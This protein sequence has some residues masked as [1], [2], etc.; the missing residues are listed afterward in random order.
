MHDDGSP[1]SISAYDDQAMP[2]QGVR[3]VVSFLLFLHFFAL[4]VGIAS[5]WSPSPLTAAVRRVPSVGPYLEFF[6]FDVSYFPLHRLTQGN[7]DDTDA[8]VEIELNATDG[9]TKQLTIPSDD[10]W[11]HQRYRR[12]ARL[13]QHVAGLAEADPLASLL[14]QDIAVHYASESTAPISK[15]TLRCRRHLMLDMSEVTSSDRTRRDP[16]DSRLY[17][18]AYEASLR[19]FRGKIQIRKREAAGENAPAAAGAGTDRSRETP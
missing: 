8:L 19:V 14:P 17:D 5:S 1:N 4:A 12:H 10:V 11:P 13:A 2:A 3:T 15:G 16:F 7:R 18:D 6:W 9:S